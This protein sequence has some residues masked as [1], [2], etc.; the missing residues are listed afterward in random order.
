MAHEVLCWYSMKRLK[1][2]PEVT[3][4]GIILAGGS[5]TRL[6]PAT[7]VGRK[8]LLAV[9]DKPRIYDPLSTLLLAGLREILVISTPRDLPS[10]EQLLGDGSWLGISIEYAPQPRP[11][12]LAQAFVIGADFVDRHPACL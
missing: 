9:Y 6:Y 5:G 3:L 8:R 2:L 10:F 4:K 7:R 1:D 12:G 11:E